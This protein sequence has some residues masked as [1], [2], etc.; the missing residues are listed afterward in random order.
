MDLLLVIFFSYLSGSIPFGLILT[1]IFVKQ[2]IRNIGK[3]KLDSDRELKSPG[4]HLPNLNLMDK[5]FDYINKFF[6]LPPEKSE[7]VR[8]FEQLDSLVVLGVSN[9]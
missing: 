3:V 8:L 4:E 7:V 6:P 1:K 2:D 9:G 5:D